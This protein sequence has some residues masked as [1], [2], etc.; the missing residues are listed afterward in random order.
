MRS[1]IQCLL[2]TQVICSRNTVQMY[3]FCYISKNIGTT[4]NLKRRE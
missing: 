3:S 4:Y 2:A 1:K